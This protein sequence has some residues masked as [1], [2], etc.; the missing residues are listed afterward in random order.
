MLRLQTLP[1]QCRSKRRP[2]G[3]GFT[4]AHAE[5][6]VLFGDR[7]SVSQAIRE[8]LCNTT[9]SVAGTPPNGVAFPRSADEAQQAVRICARHGLPIIAFGAGTS[10]EGHVNA[11]LGGL[12]VDLREMNRMIEV[13]AADFDCIVEPG[14]TRERLNEMLR[15]Q[16]CSSLWIPAPTLRSAE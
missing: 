9:A 13:H 6:I 15:D 5:L 1:L 4:A 8:Q 12:C 10:F 16:A 2:N 7:L 11:P 3:A 14:V